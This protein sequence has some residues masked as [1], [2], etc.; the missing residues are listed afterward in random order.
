[1]R[2]I[3]DVLHGATRG[4]PSFRPELPASD[5]L[6]WELDGGHRICVRPSGTEPKLKLYL[7]VREPVRGEELVAAAAARATA[8][9]DAL[10]SALHAYTAGA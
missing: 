3:I 10:A 2:A 7:D 8:T 9:L 4:E 5:M 1:V 6:I